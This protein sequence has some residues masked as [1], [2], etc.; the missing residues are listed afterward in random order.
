MKP[1]TQEIE[2]ISFETPEAPKFDTGKT[3]VDKLK[4]AEGKYFSDSYINMK[5]RKLHRQ[6]GKA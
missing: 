1:K 4:Y 6:N 5:E 3:A 2:L